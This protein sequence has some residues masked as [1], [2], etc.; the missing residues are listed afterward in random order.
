MYQRLIRARDLGQFHVAV[1]V[2]DDA[3]L[4]HDHRV[5]EVH[6]VGLG[7][8]LIVELR[9]VLGC[10]L[11]LQLLVD[12]VTILKYGGVLAGLEPHGQL[13]GLGVALAVFEQR[14]RLLEHGLAVFTVDLQLHRL[15]NVVELIRERQL[16]RNAVL[17]GAQ[18]PDPAESEAHR[19]V[20]VQTLRDLV[21]AE[22][23]R[24]HLLDGR[25]A[26]RASDQLYGFE[27]FQVQVLDAGNNQLADALHDAGFDA[28]AF[29]VL[30]AHENGDVHL[31]VADALEGDRGLRVDG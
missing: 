23:L 28:L 16:E 9:E 10:D 2:R 21:C 19:L 27:R 17:R 24:R 13:L 29:K 31:V 18:R 1:L 8:G 6:P 26:A 7:E 3:Q 11:E 12:V 4:A 25:N 30:A 5:L 20:R 14:E 15:L 22:V